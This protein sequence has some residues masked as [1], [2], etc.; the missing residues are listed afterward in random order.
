MQLHYSFAYEERYTLYAQ[1]AALNWI[2]VSEVAA[3]GILKAHVAKVRYR[4]IYH[5][6]RKVSLRIGNY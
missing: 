3:T 4:T 1:L 2:L 6:K 5:I